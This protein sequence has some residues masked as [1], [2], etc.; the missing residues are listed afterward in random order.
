MLA[1]APPSGFSNV[2]TVVVTVVEGPENIG[3]YDVRLGGA[4]ASGQ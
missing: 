3:L 1:A 2:R 4:R